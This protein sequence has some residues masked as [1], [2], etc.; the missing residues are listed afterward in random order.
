M[1]LLKGLQRKLLARLEKD[2]KPSAYA[3]GFTKGKSIISNAAYHRRKKC[4][5]KVD[6]RDF[7]PSINF[8]RVQ[9]MLQGAPF[10]F[11]AEAAVTL[12]QIT[13]LDNE[14]G[15]LPQGAATSP[16]IA[17]MICRR[18]DSRL[19]GIASPSM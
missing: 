18:L 12:A 14:G 2:F 17:N 6:I 9:G 3:H 4:I 11:G 7:F 13:C 5:I 15:V 1:E 8:G 16:Y 19:A 10:H